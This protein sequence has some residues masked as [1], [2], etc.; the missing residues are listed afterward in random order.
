[1]LLNREQI[2]DVIKTIRHDYRLSNCDFPLSCSHNLCVVLRDTFQLVRK[3]NT[4]A[5]ESFYQPHNVNL[6]AGKIKFFIQRVRRKLGISICTCNPLK[7]THD[8]CYTLRSV[9]AVADGKCC[10]LCDLTKQF[11]NLLI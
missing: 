3:Q 1:M 8:L 5:C 11:G 6:S 9:L 10:T 7:C 2:N 4:F